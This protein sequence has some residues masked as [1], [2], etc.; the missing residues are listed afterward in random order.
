MVQP[1]LADED[2]RAMKTT[3]TGK[4]G[5]REKKRTRRG[6]LELDEKLVVGGNCG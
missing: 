3:F 5:K 4:I 6:K 1:E 2:E